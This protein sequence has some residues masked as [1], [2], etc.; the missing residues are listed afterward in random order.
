VGRCSVEPLNRP[1]GSVRGS[2]VG[3]CGAGLVPAHAGVH[4]RKPTS[5]GWASGFSTGDE[6]PGL[7][8]NPTAYGLTRVDFAARPMRSH[9]PVGT[10]RLRLTSRIVAGR[11]PRRRAGSVGMY[12]Q[13]FR[14]RV[15]DFYPRLPATYELTMTIAA[16][17]TIPTTIPTRCCHHIIGHLVGDLRSS[18]ST[19]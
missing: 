14:P 13:R 18:P 1:A 19:P 6:V 10:H 5:R 4:R 9:P 3:L 12:R 17:T 7:P 2:S 15:G 8:T 11:P 16:P